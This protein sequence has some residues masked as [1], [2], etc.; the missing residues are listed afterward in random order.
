MTPDSG[1][2]LGTDGLTPSAP[3]ICSS[4]V[5]CGD[6][7]P[8]ALPGRPVPSRVSRMREG[9]VGI[10]RAPSVAVYELVENH[11]KTSTST[12]AVPLWP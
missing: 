11:P 8:G 2:T 7:A 12:W 9:V 5:C 6:S 10:K 3:R 1:T 4:M